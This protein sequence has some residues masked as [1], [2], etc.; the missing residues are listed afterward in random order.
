MR[1]HRQSSDQPQTADFSVDLL[2]ETLQHISGLHG[3]RC[4]TGTQ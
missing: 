3:W 4:C 1:L 2:I